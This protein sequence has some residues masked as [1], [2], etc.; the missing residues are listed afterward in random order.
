MEM[1]LDKEKQ[2]E[3]QNAPCYSGVTIDPKNDD[4]VCVREKLEN[5]S[6]Q[7]DEF[8]CELETLRAKL[9]G[10]MQDGDSYE[11]K[12]L[13]KNLEDLQARYQAHQALEAHL[14]GQMQDGESMVLVKN[15]EAL[16][17]IKARM[18]ELESMQCLK[19]AWH[20]LTPHIVTIS[21]EQSRRS[22][23]LL[24]SSSAMRDGTVWDV[25]YDHPAVKAAN[26]RKWSSKVAANVKAGKQEIRMLVVEGGQMYSLQALRE[27]NMC[28]FLR[29]HQV[30]LNSASIPVLHLKL[31]CVDRESAT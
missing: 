24:V 5:P 22:K 17:A 28:R 11:H 14:Q 16:Q 21:N 29:G 4:F 27:M 13:V 18:Q 26:V 2:K 1:E 8:V 6:S 23:D 19:K 12:V 7:N 20:P 30:K 15:L 10:Q 25:I 3:S 9:Q 31:V